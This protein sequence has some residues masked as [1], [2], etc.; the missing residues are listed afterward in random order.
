M[1]LFGKPQ[2]ESETTRSVDDGLTP[3][4]E[5]DATQAVGGQIPQ[6]D[7]GNIGEG[8]RGDPDLDPRPEI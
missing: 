1:I 5:Q 6:I 3:L 8:G 7:T 4:S 2:T